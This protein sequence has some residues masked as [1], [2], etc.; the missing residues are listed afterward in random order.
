MIVFPLVAPPSRHRCC[1][2]WGRRR[3][4]Q[5]G[6]KLVLRKQSKP[7]SGLGFGKVRFFE[8]I[9]PVLPHFRPHSL[10]ARGLVNNWEGLAMLRGIFT[11]RRSSR[12]VIGGKDT[13]FPQNLSPKFM[14]V[15]ECGRNGLSLTLN[16][17][18]CYRLWFFFLLCLCWVSTKD[19]GTGSGFRWAP[20]RINAGKV[21][22]PSVCLSW[23]KFL[24]RRKAWLNRKVWFYE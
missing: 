19:K 13:T 8:E 18:F 21:L 7:W 4:W 10:V 22:W 6:A 11:L 1:P 9:G 2:L 23:L 14:G 3:I 17:F 16:G 20:S 5:T 12:G 15:G 24:S